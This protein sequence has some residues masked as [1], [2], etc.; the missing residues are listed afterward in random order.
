MARRYFLCICVI[1][2]MA[3]AD[4]LTLRNGRVVEGTYLGGD[5]R[6]VRMLTGGDK[7]ES[8]EVSEIATLSFG[9]GGVTPAAPVTAVAAPA[10]GPAP[11]PDTVVAAAPA[12]PVVAAAPAE[13]GATIVPAAPVVAAA[14]AGVVLASRR[15]EIPAGTTIV[16]RMIDDVDSKR[17]SMGKTFRASVDEPVQI[18][19]DTVIP[20]GADLVAKLV[21]EKNSGVFTGKT[22]MTMALTQITL[23]GRNYELVT[24]DVVEAS[25][26]RTGGTVKKAAVLGGIG[27]AIGGIA[28][29]G[30]GAAIGGAAGAGAGAGMQVLTR[31]QRVKIPSEGRLAF[32]L[33]Q[34]LKL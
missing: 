32:K 30:S 7:V 1:A 23:N 17:D 8:F 14:P 26:S 2:A 16:A 12:T 18:G 9:A 33:K 6:Q 24:E 11:A 3:A 5:A 21:D 15:I 25:E 20:R 34:P 28:G 27:A 22:E 10:A 13:S 29:G 19:G 4:T 31:G